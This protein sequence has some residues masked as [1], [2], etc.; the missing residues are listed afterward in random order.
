MYVSADGREFTEVAAG[1]WDRDARLKTA[2]FAA[3]DARYVR[4]EAH[5]ASGGSHASAAEVTAW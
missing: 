2:S 1:T 4:L 3:A 5:T